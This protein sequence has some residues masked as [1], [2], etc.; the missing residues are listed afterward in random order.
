M[1]QREYSS[2]KID[3]AHVSYIDNQPCLDLIESGK[4]SIL[5]MADEELKLP[6]G[7]R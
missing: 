1:E 5:G 7:G 3:V 6:G 4:T 2:E